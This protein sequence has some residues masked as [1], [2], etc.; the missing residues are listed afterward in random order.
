MFLQYLS[1]NMALGQTVRAR[2]DVAYTALKEVIAKPRPTRIVS[3]ASGPAMELR[4]L[5]QSI[6]T[7]D[8]KVEIFLV[9]QD[10]EALR[11]GLSALNKIC[12]ERG[13]NLP[14]EFHCLHFSLRQLIAPK[15]GAESELVHNVLHNELSALASRSR[16]QK[17]I[18]LQY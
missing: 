8:H 17:F 14:I 11:N 2:S 9:D 10:E 13:D 1:Q 18:R 5:L 7:L 12:V 4:R 15:K 3:L 16:F 6:A